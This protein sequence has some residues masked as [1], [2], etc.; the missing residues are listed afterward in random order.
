MNNES[1]LYPQFI[2]GKFLNK[3]MEYR[4]VAHSSDFN[5]SKIDINDISMKYKFWGTIKPNGN[6]KAVGAFR[7]NDTFL[8]FQVAPAIKNRRLC[9]DGSNS[10]FIQLRYVYI[11]IQ[12][13]AILNYR[14]FPLLNWLYKQDIPV[15]DQFND[16]LECLSIPLL[17]RP[18]SSE[19]KKQELANLEK[20]LDNT[21]KDQNPFILST[22]AV[23]LNKGKLILDYCRQTE[24]SPSS[25]VY[26]KNLLSLLPANFRAYWA[27]ALGTINEKYCFEWAEILYKTNSKPESFSTNTVFFNTNEKQFLRRGVDKNVLKHDYI[28]DII[29]PITKEP[30]RLS[31]L[32]SRLDKI[33]EV[34]V[35]DEQRQILP[36]EEITNPRII[37]RLIPALPK[38]DQIKLRD[39]YLLDLKVKDWETIIP[40]IETDESA[41]LIAVDAMR[42]DII[43]GRFNS[44]QS[45]F[46]LLTYLS[47]N[48]VEDFLKKL[49]NNFFLGETL[50]NAKLL[51]QPPITS[52]EEIK[53]EARK[54]CQVIVK[55][56]SRQEGLGK[57]QEF[58]TNLINDA[59]FP[60]SFQFRLFDT[61]L[62]NKNIVNIN[63]IYSFFNSTLA[64]L[65]TE[66][67]A[68]DFI[69]KSYLYQRLQEANNSG[70]IVEQISY[71]LEHKNEVSQLPA[72]AK[73]TKM[74]WQDEY[75]FL[76]EF[77]INFEPD[78]SQ[79]EN[80]LINLF[81]QT[82]KN[83]H[84]YS[85]NTYNSQSF[86]DITKV[87]NTTTRRLKV[88]ENIHLNPLSWD[89]WQ[90]IGEDLYKNDLE[91]INKF[92]DRVYEVENSFLPQVL[93]HWLNDIAEKRNLL[94]TFTE[95]SYLWN[96]IVSESMIRS[97]IDSLIK[98]P[99]SNIKIPVFIQCFTHSKN[100]NLISSSLIEAFIGK[101][102]QQSELMPF[103]LEI[104]STRENSA[105]L[106]E[107]YS[108]YYYEHL[109]TK[110][111][112][113][114][115]EWKEQAKDEDLYKE[116]FK[117]AISQIIVQ[118]D[119]FFLL[120]IYEKLDLLE[121]EIMINA[122]Q[123]KLFNTEN[124][125]SIG[126]KF[127][128]D[129]AK[130]II[131]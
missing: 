121:Q 120:Y 108:K 88:L 22:L 50:L 87:N 24:N 38:E 85:S 17:D 47:K 81:E 129:L 100:D 111:D 18:L 69:H 4:I 26:I 1:K 77:L 30:E 73:L 35:A 102:K 90:Q 32:L 74:T 2:K 57:A 53:Q 84:Q 6:D 99:S 34:P 124:L 93:E 105:I 39:K 23:L 21:D 127:I 62:D 110:T 68:K 9:V 116:S 128:Q 55:E 13:L 112:Y 8:L 80:L 114:F 67:S 125:I 33:E 41:L 103:L 52:D 72:I 48:L 79:F 70:Q 101:V 20:C 14:L 49:Q 76:Q 95:D 113:K 115:K 106:R 46:I 36:V 61:I 15:F 78:S 131:S 3:R 91:K 64:P 19:S 59:I 44:I 104:K 126:I 11:P 98:L 12:D 71:L 60:D 65:L 92:F 109:V 119:F 97:E 27:I 123:E 58:A 118:K 28:T 51:D 31:Y 5:Q 10:P 117:I 56:K 86:S 16:T 96:N 89:M 54:L 45:I 7:L 25:D 29:Q 37:I 40:L 94:A 107:F 43:Q 130:K 82:E 122:F 83:K 63:S 42:Q 75:K 66:I